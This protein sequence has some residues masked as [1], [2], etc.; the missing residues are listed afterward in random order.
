MIMVI[1]NWLKTFR[2]RISLSSRMLRKSPRRLARR[3]LGQPLLA[4]QVTPLETRILPSA[5]VVKDVWEGFES[6][7]VIPW[8]ELDGKLLFTANDGVHGDELWVTDGTEG[9]TLLLKDIIV[10]DEYSGSYPSELVKAGDLVFFRAI[11]NEHNAELWRTDGTPEGTVMVKDITPDENDS[12]PTDLTVVNGIVYFAASDENEDRELWRSNGTAEGTYRVK[13]ILPGSGHDDSSVPTNLMNVNGTLFFTARGVD[14]RELWTSDGTEGG[15]VQVMDIWPGATESYISGM[16]VVGSTLYFTANDGP[17]PITGNHGNELWK[18]DGTEAGTVMVKDIAPGPASS[19]PQGGVAMNGILYFI[20]KD[21][22]GGYDLWRSDG[23]SVGTYRI[24]D[25]TA[26]EGIPSLYGLTPIG[27]TLYFAV[28][29]DYS[30]EDDYGQTD[31][32]KSDGTPEGTEFITTVSP[33]FYGNYLG[34]MTN[35]QGTLYFT[36]YNA[37]SAAELWKSDGTAAGTTVIDLG[38]AAASSPD[39]YYLTV[40]EDAL[41]F[42][43]TTAT[44]GEELW[45]LELDIVENLPPVVTID[46]TSGS[47]P[48]GT[49]GLETVILADVLL[50]DDGLGAHIFSLSGPDAEYF[51]LLGDALLSLKAGTV[52]DFETKQTYSVTVNVDD[53]SIGGAVDTSATFTLNVTNVNELPTV[54]LTEVLS[55]LAED[56]DTAAAIEVATIQIADDAL[57]TNVLSLDGADAAFFEIVGGSL[58]LKAGTVLNAEAKSTYSVTVNLNDASIGGAVDSSA[59]FTL[60]VTNVNQPPSVSLTGVTSTRAENS[61]SASAVTVATIQVSDDALGTNVLSLSGADAE[62][63]EIVGNSL[64]LKAG[65]NLDFETKSTYDVTV[66]VNDGTVGSTPDDTVDYTLNVT[67]VNELPT[68]SLTEVASTLAENTSTASAIEVATIQIADDALGTNV[69][70]LAG[71]DAASFEIVGGSL[72]LKAGTVLNFESKST[73]SVTVNLND[74]SIGGAV[75]SSATFTLNITDVNEPPSVSLTG[76][77]SSLAES[78]S[79]VSAITVATIQVTD[80][81]HVNNDQVLSLAGDD[82][83]FFEIVGSSLRLKAGVALNFEAKSSYTVTVQVD[84][85]GLGS[86]PDGSVDYTLSVTNVNEAPTA[87]ILSDVT[88]T[89]SEHASTTSAI[90]VATI[91][92]TDD[93]LGTETLSLS[94]PDAAFFQIVGNQ[95]RLKAGTVLDF[96]TKSTYSVTINVNDAAVGGSPDASVAYSLTLT[97][98]D[99]TQVI[100]LSNNVISE[101]LKKGTVVGTLSMNLPAAKPKYTLVAGAGGADNARFSISGGQLKTRGVLNFEAQQTYTVRVQ[102]KDGNKPPVF[103]VFL[104]SVTDVNEPPT[105]LNLSNLKVTENNTPGHGIGTFSTNDADT[106]DS[107]TYTLV[108][109]SGSADNARFVI[110]DNELRAVGS[111]D[112]EQKKKYSIRVRV[113]DSSGRWYE[114]KFTITVTNVRDPR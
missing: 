28:G 110:V 94:G 101:G 29:T 13:D 21:P 48:E 113:T 100:A 11:T 42:V 16:T 102:M 79:T 3:R 106:G 34:N 78:T 54:S 93:A 4:G 76:V 10:G 30:G 53:P 60:T 68:V 9:G 14:G 64:R 58:R 22:A 55:T 23:S 47:Q 95:L 35:V 18:S 20:A 63:F 82:A 56:A 62:F 1:R 105:V 67:N 73:Y 90:V 77:T 104:I 49:Y 37:Q 89:L 6:S 111:F 57:G 5:G 66:E 103:A 61:S 32:W 36:T 107:W 51:E 25:V 17:D 92:V 108:P 52:L 87:V 98:E 109:G 46:P 44:L 39:P 114:R 45:K 71:T 19:N 84:D 24:L 27:G 8:V 96:E 40:F 72:R 31:L 38:A 75:D 7:D 69:L 59:T 86:S 91:D 33:A 80:D 83:E 74:A 112:Y 81:A 65:T 97:D 12:T 99:D 41:Y 50:T 43:A 85:E 15:T 2:A 70:S 26:D 88:S